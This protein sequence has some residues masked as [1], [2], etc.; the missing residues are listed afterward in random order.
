MELRNRAE[1]INELLDE[2]DEIEKQARG[3]QSER[4]SSWS[5]QQVRDF[6]HRYQSWYASALVFLPDDLKEQFMKEFKNGRLFHGIE[7]FISG[8]TKANAVFAQAALENPDAISSLY[9]QYPV[10]TTF[11]QRFV[12]QQALLRQARERYVILSTIPDQPIP[13]LLGGPVGAG[14]AEAN[15]ATKRAGVERQAR[16]EPSQPVVFVAHGRSPLYM[17]VYHHLKDDL[18]LEPVAF[19]TEDHTSEQISEILNQYLDRAIVAVIVMTGE[20][21]TLDNRLLAR[22]NVVHEAG[23]FQA[24]LGFERVAILKEEG[25]ESFSNAQGL[26]YIPFNPQD[27]TSCFY[28]LRRFLA[29]HQLVSS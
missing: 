5:E 20:E 3:I 8:P 12:N 24:K 19:E 21:K 1:R 22:Q 26:I 2:A 23:L 27:I 17:Q 13:G 10:E 11:E 18:H 7:G 29:R 15:P 16:I 25:V 14:P 6:R 28:K 4:P 9:W